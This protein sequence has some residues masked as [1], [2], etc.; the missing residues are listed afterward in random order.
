[1]RIYREADAMNYL[2]EDDVKDCRDP[3]EMAQFSA[4]PGGMNDASYL[5]PQDVALARPDESDGLAWI[6]DLSYNA[7]RFVY[8]PLE[9]PARGVPGGPPHDYPVERPD[10]P[11]HYRNWPMYHAPTVLRTWIQDVVDLELVPVS[12]QGE[13]W[14]TS[15]E[16][17]G[18]VIGKALRHYGWP[19]E[20]REQDW[21][22]DSEQIYRAAGEVEERYEE[23]FDSH[24]FGRDRKELLSQWKRIQTLSQMTG[25]P[26]SLKFATF[27]GLWT[28][29]NVCVGI[30]GGTQTSIPPTT[31]TT[32]AGN[33]ISTPLSTQPVMVNNCDR[34]YFVQ[35]GDSCAQIAS[36]HGI[37]VTE[38]ATWNNVSGAA[39]GGL[40]ANVCVCV[41]VIGATPT[42]AVPAPPAPGNGVSTPV[43][44]Q[45]GMVGNCDRFYFVE[46]GDTCVAIVSRYGITLTQFTTWNNVVGSGCGGL[47]ANVWVCVHI[48]G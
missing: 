32:S 5:L 4:Q 21:A 43:P 39:C 45:P 10:D 44:T 31:T 3:H 27:G 48:L 42:T 17:L 35:S 29:G 1:M 34:F 12:S 36:N 47:W 40:W 7:F 6:L 8:G 2:E 11:D 20:F 19:A 14:S 13:Y 38:L 25:K 30:I 41:R 33:G 26:Q 37:S 24:K 28:N 22:R 18:Q 9:A 23:E 46:S 15:S 16:I